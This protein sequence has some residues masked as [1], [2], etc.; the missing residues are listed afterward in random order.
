MGIPDGFCYWLD[1]KRDYIVMRWDWI[2][3]DEQGRET[4]TESDVTEETA[5]SPKG[6]WHATRVRREFSGRDGKAKSPDQIYHIYVD[7]NVNLPDSLFEPPK[8]GRID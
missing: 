7:F 8:P 1:L 2:T 4:V 3:R 6:V 5:R